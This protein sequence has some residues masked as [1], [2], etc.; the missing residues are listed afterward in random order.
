MGNIENTNQIMLDGYICKA[1]TYRVTPFGREI[2]DI[3]IAVNR[4]YNKSDYIPA[5]AWG[6]NA[7]F[8]RYAKSRMAVYSG[9]F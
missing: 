6:R 8:C 9:S 4:S 5:I 7:K 2:A 3:L 1:P